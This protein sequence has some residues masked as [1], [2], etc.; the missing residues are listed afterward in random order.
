MPSSKI[1]EVMRKLVETDDKDERMNIVEENQEILTSTENPDNNEE[2][3]NLKTQ[4]GE[5]QT[6]LEEQKK[7][8]R[9]RFF[10]GINEEENPKDEE[11]KKEEPK[12]LS[13]IL[14]DKGGN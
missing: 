7:K 1:M 10:G 9:D 8:F 4:N 11:E 2:M 3:E 6:A 13:K 12:T 14:N 5:L